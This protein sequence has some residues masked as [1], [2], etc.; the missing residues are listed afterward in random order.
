MTRNAPGDEDRLVLPAGRKP[1]VLVVGDPLK[2]AA[3]ELAERVRKHLEGRAELLGV[4][5]ERTL[6]PIRL[7]PDLLV[8]VGG[9]GALL[10]ATRRLGECPAPV[11]GVNV[12]TV[13][14]LAGVAP[15]RLLAVLDLALAGQGVVEERGMLAYRATR[16]GAAG[17]EAHVLND[18]V[19]GRAPERG[20]CEVGLVDVG[21][22]VCTYRGDGVIVSTAT[23]STAY[24]LAA[25]GPVLSPRLDALVVTP[26]A[27]HMLGMRPLVLPGARGI[28]LRLGDEA[29]L[30]ADG[31][32]EG[33]LA[34][35][36][37]VQVMPSERRLRLIVDPE[38]GFYARLRSKLRWGEAP[39]PG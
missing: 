22:S 25:G 7:E 11:M 5:L 21:R 38:Q 13:G 18:V 19:V 4:M 2:P 20:M 29:A 9:D 14:F 16:G 36:D 6:E 24:N 3:K 15:P 28:T 1:R 30:S 10:A 35:G 26:I 31:R 34:A 27:P 33:L 17:E 39:G 8:V 32:A 12:G 23:G 37:E